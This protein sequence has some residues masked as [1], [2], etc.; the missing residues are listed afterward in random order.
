MPGLVAKA[1]LCPGL[2]KIKSN[3]IKSKPGKAAQEE[4][5][6]GG[7]VDHH[8]THRLVFQPMAQAVHRHL[9]AITLGRMNGGYHP[10]AHQP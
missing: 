4:E 1:V 5:G 3:K 6:E 10:E 9:L 2:T 8:A 7:P